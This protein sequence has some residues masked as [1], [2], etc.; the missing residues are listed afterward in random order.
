MSFAFH[1][2]S[3]DW[4][5]SGKIL[6]EAGDAIERDVE[7]I[8][9]FDVPYV[10]GYP[11]KQGKKPK[12]YI[13][14]KL[15]KGF[16]GPEGFF[17]V[18][19]PIIVHEAIEDGLLDLIPS[20]VYQLPH[21]FALH[22]ERSLVEARGMDWTTYNTWCMK[23]IKEIGGRDHYPNCPPDLDLKPYFDEEDWATLKKMFANGKPLWDGRKV[24]P[25]VQ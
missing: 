8:T 14:H 5:L 2:S 4:L 1:R 18:F 25:G 15:P 6:D 3:K 20:L 19:E 22:G 10:A 17:N 16:D 9:D 11:N 7:I 24:H 21:Q 12:F 23:Q 13:D